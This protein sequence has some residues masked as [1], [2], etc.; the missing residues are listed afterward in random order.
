MNKLFSEEIWQKCVL[1]YSPS[2]NLI[3]QNIKSEFISKKLN[4]YKKTIRKQ[5]DFNVW[6]DTLEDKVFGMDQTWSNSTSMNSS[7]IC[8]PNDFLMQ[9]RF[10]NKYDLNFVLK[11]Y[12]KFF[13]K[14][15]FYND[16]IMY[17]NHHRY[18]DFKGSKILV[19]A[20]GPSAKNYDWNEKDYDYVF[21][22]NHFYLNSKIKKI[23]VDFAVIGGEI[24]MS[25]R[26][27]EFHNYFQNNNTLLCFEDRMSPKSAEFF[28]EM[29]HK[30]D[31]RCVYMH[32]RYRGKPGVGP[33]LLLYAAFLQP[34]EIHFAGIDGMAHNTKRGDLHDHAFQP[35]KAYSHKA[36]NYGVY[37]RH[38]V[39]LWDYIINYLKLNNKI[40]LQ[41]LGE[42][43]DRNQSTSISKNYFPLEKNE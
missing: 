25:E 4:D 31:N 39:L 16:E 43:M 6:Y 18:N 20:G 11:F 12:G 2:L 22:C 35:G 34:S 14:N 41:N 8:D 32:S 15:M 5:I 17:L 30:Y 23:D 36:L 13:G 3:N 38:Y 37:R 42:G 33:R 1:M 24:D 26:N 27:T 10:K 40:K 9:K 19:L 7:F 21:S 28:A 29:K